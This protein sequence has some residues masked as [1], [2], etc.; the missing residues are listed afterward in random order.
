VVLYSI[1]VFLTFSLSLYGLTIYWWRQVGT[2]AGAVGRLA[3]ALLGLVISVGILAG[4]LVAKFTH[5]A[6]MTVLITGFV[7]GVCLL[8][9]RHYAEVAALLKEA[10]DVFAN[11]PADRVEAGVVPLDPTAPTAVFLV[12]RSLGTGMH[13]L[14]TALRL[15]PKQFRNFIFLTACEVEAGSYREEEK[16]DEL[17]AKVQAHL[18]R[19][20][21]FC[22][23]RG[24][25]AT[26]MCQFG[27]DAAEQLTELC[28]RT[29]EGF[30]R[31]VFFAAKLVFKREN[32]ANRLLHNQTAFALQ[33]RLHLRGQTLV[34][35]PIKL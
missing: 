10:D 8:I 16:L 17:Q 34:I 14:L 25:A 27:S 29:I 5:G 4:T 21:V 3:L 11:L 23:S 13:T 1:N 12:G 19:Y 33:R 18:E 26:S 15:F 28:E 20:V 35:L 7:V 24:L 30:P 32:A 31:C 22:T 2:R 9:A 6:W